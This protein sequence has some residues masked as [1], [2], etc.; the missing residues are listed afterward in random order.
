M[1][2][3]IAELVTEELT[4]DELLFEE[5][6]VMDESDAALDEAGL[7]L[8]LEPLTKGVIFPTPT[9]AITISGT[10]DE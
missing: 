1:L 2:D 10:V 4:T 9:L 8:L 5:L 6:L 7:E 3:E